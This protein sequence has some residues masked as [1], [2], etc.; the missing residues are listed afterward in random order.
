MQNLPDELVIDL[1]KPVT[2]GSETYTQLVLREPTAGEVA[3]A[4]KAGGGLAS[5]IVLIAL[6]SG[7]PKPGVERIGY[8][9]TQRAVQYLA[10]FMVGGPETGGT[11]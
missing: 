9:D 1:R 3:Q 11:P 2:L 6:V 10:G 8:R 4:Q 5:D 7:V